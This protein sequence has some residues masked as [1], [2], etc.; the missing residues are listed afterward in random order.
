MSIRYL[1]LKVVNVDMED[2]ENILTIQAKSTGLGN[3]AGMM[4]NTYQSYYK[5]AYLPDRYRKIINQKKYNEDRLTSYDRIRQ[6]AHRGSFISGSLSCDYRIYPECRD[7]FSALYYIRR[8]L[9]K[10]GKIYLDANGLIWTAEYKI[11][12]REEI[13]TFYGSE[14]AFIVDIRFKKISEGSSERSDMLTNNLVNEENILTF[15]IAVTD[16][17]LPLKARYSKKPFPV[18]WILESYE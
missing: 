15:W 10:P 11:T 13:D 2:R 5:G 8:H 9:D 3:M 4:D 18:F 14:E 12:G 7:F 1:G 16:N 6:T 17:R